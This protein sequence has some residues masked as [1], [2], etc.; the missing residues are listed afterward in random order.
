MSIEEYALLSKEDRIDYACLFEP[1]AWR[2]KKPRWFYIIYKVDNYYAELKFDEFR[3]ER[4]AIEARPVSAE[5]F[6]LYLK[7]GYYQ[8]VYEDY[9]PLSK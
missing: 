7:D 3:K 8:V 6:K 5:M 4:L 1:V 2:E 9:T